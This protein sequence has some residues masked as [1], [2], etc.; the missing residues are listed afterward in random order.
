MKRLFYKNEG[1]FVFAIL[2]IY[3]LGSMLCNALSG[4]FSL[5]YIITVSFLLALSLY[6]IIFFKK[7]KVSKYY[8]LCQGKIDLFGMMLYMPPA[9]MIAVMIALS[10]F[11]FVF[12]FIPYN[13]I[14]VSLLVIYCVLYSFIN[15]LIYR[16]MIYRSISN[17]SEIVAI[18]FGTIA[19]AWGPIST[20]L[21]SGRGMTLIGAFNVLNMIIVGFMLTSMFKFNESIWPQVVIASSIEIINT[22]QNMLMPFGKSLAIDIVVF[23][24]ASGYSV[25][26]WIAYKNG[27]V[28][29]RKG[30]MKK[31][32][33]KNARKSSNKKST[34]NIIQ[35]KK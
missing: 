1:L 3:L 19:F 35:F 33:A 8:G 15:E 4:L 25:F 31:K 5:P 32:K 22:F 7:E 18:I 34:N 27:G 13:I 16:S 12:D 6:L 10:E 24:C 23:I 28:N 11:N 30:K 26:L 21:M 29:K 17:V 9:V 2:V 20:F 14:N